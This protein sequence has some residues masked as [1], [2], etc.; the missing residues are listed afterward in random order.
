VA[1]IVAD[2]CKEIAGYIGRVTQSDV[3]LILALVATSTF[4]AILL[5]VVGP[6]WAVLFFALVSLVLLVIAGRN[7]KEADSP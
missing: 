6:I 5:V 3:A 4:L 1:R 2:L 7:R